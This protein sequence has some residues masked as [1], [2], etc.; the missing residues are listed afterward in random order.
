MS[1]AD[2]KFG[3]QIEGTGFRISGYIYICDLRIM[4]LGFMF[5]IQGLGFGMQLLGFRV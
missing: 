5:G 4:I 2:S 3:I 1:N